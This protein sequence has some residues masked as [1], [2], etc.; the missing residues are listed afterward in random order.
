MKPSGLTGAAVLLAAILLVPISCTRKEQ[1]P[2]KQDPSA[3][4]KPSRVRPMGQPMAVARKAPPPRRRAAP[5]RPASVLPKR[6]APVPQPL[7]LVAFLAALEATGGK[8]F[9]PKPLLKKHLGNLDKHGWTETL[10]DKLT[11][12]VLRVGSAPLVGALLLFTPDKFKLCDSTDDPVTV[13]VMEYKPRKGKPYLAVHVLKTEFRAGLKPKVKFPKNFATTRAFFVE[14]E[15]DENLEGCQREAVKLGRPADSKV[16]LMKAGRRKLIVVESYTTSGSDGAW[17]QTT[18][19]SSSL[20]W[21]ASTDPSVH[22]LG[23]VVTVTNRCVETGDPDSTD[24]QTNF[25]TSGMVIGMQRGKYWKYY[26]GKKLTRLRAL[27]PSLKKLPKRA[28]GG[29]SD[30]CNPSGD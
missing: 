30:T 28:S 21:Y 18:D 23:V 27:E 13:S 12:K 3:A 6:P 26:R 16:A 22:Y 9:E 29:N 20:T 2:S 14:Y 10:S 24:E 8:A 7:K 1:K 15:Y 11:V 19:T 25:N 4:K 5:M 17:G